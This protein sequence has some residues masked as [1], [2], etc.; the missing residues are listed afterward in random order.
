M[1]KDVPS[2]YTIMKYFS[3]LFKLKLEIIEISKKLLLRLENSF[4]R[5]FSSFVARFSFYSE[6]FVAKS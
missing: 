1:S 2:F 5:K 6:N 4:E 3:T